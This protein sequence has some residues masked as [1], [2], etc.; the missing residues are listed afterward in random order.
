MLKKGG[1]RRW[2]PILSRMY[3]DLFNWAL[4]PGR[5][6]ADEARKCA[7]RAVG[8]PWEAVW[9]QVRREVSQM[10][11]DGLHLTFGFSN[12]KLVSMAM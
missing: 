12:Q 9:A 10:W 4:H 7:K 5:V 8:R 11:C 1:R 3:A 6:T 2:R